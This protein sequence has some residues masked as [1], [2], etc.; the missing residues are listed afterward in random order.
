MSGESTFMVECSEV[1]PVPGIAMRTRHPDSPGV[2][3]EKKSFRAA[4][5]V[6]LVLSKA[7]VSIHQSVRH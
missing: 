3:S 1:W 4:P 7:C 2:L 6:Q 5:H